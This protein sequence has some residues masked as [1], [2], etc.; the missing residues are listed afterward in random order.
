MCV[1]EE[2]S[3]S[4]A[5]IKDLPDGIR[6]LLHLKVVT[7]TV[8]EDNVCPFYQAN[9]LMPVGLL[10]VRLPSLLSCVY[11]SFF[12]NNIV[13]RTEIILIYIVLGRFGHL[14]APDQA[15]SLVPFLAVVLLLEALAE[16]GEQRD[17]KVAWPRAHPR[18]HLPS[19]LVRLLFLFF[20]LFLL[21][22]FEHLLELCLILLVSMVHLVARGLS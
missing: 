21:L 11:F 7:D 1:S 13:I 22:L 18:C 4:Q 10:G 14:A 2:G 6:S 17:I 3:R 5:L 8:L 15:P 12:F 16:E 20:L 9:L 19:L